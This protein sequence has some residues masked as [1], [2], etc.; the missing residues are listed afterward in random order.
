MPPARLQ[1]LYEMLP[2]FRVLLDRYDPHGKFRNAFV[3]AYIDG[4]ARVS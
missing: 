3:Q 2:Q 1:P 4:S